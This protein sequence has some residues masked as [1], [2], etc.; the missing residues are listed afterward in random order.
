MRA[1]LLILLMFLACCISC[2][3]KGEGT[4]QILIQNRTE[5]TI[6]ITLFP[7]KTAPGTNMLYPTC[8]GCGGYWKTKFNLLPNNDDTYKWD[9]VLFYTTDLDTQPYTLAAKAFDSIYISS[10]N[11]DNIIIKFAH[12]TVSGYS[13][14]IFAQNSTWDYKTIKL[15]MST[16]I[17]KTGTAHCYRFL[18][19]KDKIIN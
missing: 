6:H 5:N 1:I 17:K 11:K 15:D 18:I 14:N 10:A 16:S 12:E 19:L 8:E 13:E 4:L 9:E 2:K 7:K 3:E